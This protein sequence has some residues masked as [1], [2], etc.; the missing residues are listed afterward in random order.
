MLPSRETLVAKRVVKRQEDKLRIVSAAS[1]FPQYVYDQE[2][3]TAFLSELWKDQLPKP[4]LLERLHKNCG[5]SR[6]HFSMPLEEYAGIENFGQANDKWIETAAKLG[7][8]AIIRAVTGAG[9]ALKDID[10]IYFTSITGISNPS[11]DALLTNR[12]ALSPTIK[13]TPIFGLGCVGGAVG[14][15]RAS[16]YVRAFPDQIALVLSVELCSLT[17][18]RKDCS[19]AN[20]ISV[21]LFGDGAAAVIVAGA[22]TDI[23]QDG[24]Q[25]ISTR[26]SFYPDTEDVMGWKINENGFEI[27]LSAGVPDVVKKYFRSDLD[28]FLNDHKLRSNNIS[29]WIIHPGGPK[30]LTAI[31]RALDLPADALDLSW[32][33][34]DRV[35]NLSSAS[36]LV[37]L[38]D[39]LNAHRCAPDS[40]GIMAALGPGFCSEILLLKW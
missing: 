39:L 33:C 31:T 26:A 4:G 36:V 27:V 40:Y 11:I 25:I 37:V 7:E 20:L 23:G 35:G 8:V 2:T 34:L 12:L 14:I 16:D 3:V 28:A 30:V 17:W 38:E 6:R 19:I 13:R 32:K 18:Q 5:V 15:T 24:P 22:Q 1:A 21:G 29:S 10:A 9:I